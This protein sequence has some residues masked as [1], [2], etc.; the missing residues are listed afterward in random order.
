MGTFY[1]VMPVYTWRQFCKQGYLVG[2]KDK[3]LFPTEYEWM[4]EQMHKRIPNYQ[5]EHPVWLW[6]EYPSHIKSGFVKKRQSGVVLTLEIP[7]ELVLL[8]DF[9]DWHCVLNNVPCA[10]SEEEYD[11]FYEGKLSMTLEESWERIFNLDMHRDP[12]WFGNHPYRLQGVTGKTPIEWVK[13]VKYFR[14]KQKRD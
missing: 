5:G 8:S 10:I 1:T 2:N 13:K 9:D 3:A 7:D 4:I 6:T 14:G 12:D 11:A